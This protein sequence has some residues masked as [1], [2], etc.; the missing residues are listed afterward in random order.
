VHLRD[1]FG[2]FWTK[3][4]V[5]CKERATSTQAGFLTETL[6]QYGD[7]DLHMQVNRLHDTVS[8]LFVQLQQSQGQLVETQNEL[9][10]EYRLSIRTFSS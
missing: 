7:V 8:F 5:S 4:Q 9:A 3:V 1:D 6:L 10:E 2:N